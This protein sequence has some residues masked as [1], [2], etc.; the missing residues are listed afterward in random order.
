MTSHDAEIARIQKEYERRVREIPADYYALHR[1]VNLFF[2][3]TEERALFAGLLRHGMLPLAGKRVLE[4]GCGYGKWF[5]TFARLGAS[6]GDVAGL[7]LDADNLA[8]A[9]AG[10]P[11][12]ELVVGDA[13]KLPWPDHSFDLVLQSTVFTS[14]LD[15]EVKRAVARDMARVLAPHGVIVWYDFLVDNPWNPN[16][17]GVKPKEIAALFPGFRM[18]LDRV[19]LWPMLARRLVP[20]SW[21]LST[22]VQALRFLNTHGLAVLKRA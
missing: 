8:R 9:R 7:D 15:A 5:D 17:R 1:S 20:I 21:T 2:R 14:I 22:V 19:T 16:V 4:V 3:H 12:C 13:A 10:Y 6:L 11:A 18:S